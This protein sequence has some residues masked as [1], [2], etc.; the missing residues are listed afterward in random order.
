MSVPTLGQVVNGP[1]H[2]VHYGK[3]H[4]AGTLRGFHCVDHWQRQA[5]DEP[6]SF[7]AHGGSCTDV[8]TTHRTV[9]ALAADLPV[10]EPFLLVADL[11]NPHDICEWIGDHQG[12][13]SRELPDAQLPP[14]PSNFA[15]LDFDTRPMAV[16]DN[17]PHN[18]RMPQTRGW[19]PV[20]Y[21]HYLAAYRSYVQRVDRDV[22]AILDGLDARADADRTLVVLLADHGEG[23]A[24]HGFVTKG[25]HFYE[26]CARVPLVM[27]GPGIARGAACD[28][29]LVSLLDVMPT[30]ADAL[31]YT[32][33]DGID[34]QSLWP[35]V[36][37]RA[38]RF[39]RQA[40]CSWWGDG[41][42][43]APGHMLRTLTHKYVRF[44]DA[45]ELYD[46]EADPGEMHNLAV[47]PSHRGSIE[48]HRQMQ[49]QTALSRGSVAPT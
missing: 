45:E 1:H 17:G 32:P 16:R 6:P 49:R 15:R 5:P 23:L 20:H 4:D 37:G 44:E 47:V 12:P 31:G 13:F 19:Q 29:S 39:N 35:L 11:C 28:S 24:E 14:L 34:G 8:Y 38:G 43:G 7:K 36:T 30:V 18:F 41:S 3:T 9:Q 2:K 25:G 10:D 33:P 48:Q 22:A 27:A 46:L 26:S 21:R 42:A 40:V